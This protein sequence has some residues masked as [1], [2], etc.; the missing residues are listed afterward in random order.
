MRSKQGGE[1]G[2]GARVR[3]VLTSV[4]I[5]V[6]GLAQVAACS[7]GGD[8]GIA[9]STATAEQSGPRRPGV[10]PEV[11]DLTA[12]AGLGTWVDAYDYSPAFVDKGQPAVTPA[13]VAD[14]A[15]VGVDTLYL[16]AAKDDERSPGM[17]VDAKLVGRFLVRAHA[18]GMRVVAWFLP[19]LADIE[20]D[21]KRLEHLL[22][23]E[24]DG[25]RFD[26]VAVDIEWV[27][28]VPDT[29]TRNRRVVALSERVDMLA[30]GDPLGAIVLPPVATEVIN[31][32][33]W[34]AFPYRKL[35]PYFGVWMTMGYWTF[36]SEESGYRDAARYTDENI[37]RLRANLGDSNVPVHP[38]GGIGDKSTRSD[39]EGF[40]AAAREQR[41]VGWSVYD[42]VTTSSAAWPALRRPRA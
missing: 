2:Y 6:L 28:S 19:K 25:Q 39:Y 32:L 8:P 35:A 17:L 11:R 24:I 7:G 1:V 18:R 9:E 27:D 20:A 5:V 14:M 22:E 42:F 40:V 3:R 33:L 37:R 36:R 10:T 26:G 4:L 34:P 29:A 38:I 21:A 12:Y 13:S 31:P 30:A 16:Q 23:Y 15:A 41:A